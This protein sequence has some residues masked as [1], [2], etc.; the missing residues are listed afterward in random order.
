MCAA[1]QSH[2]RKALLPPKFKRGDLP[3]KAYLRILVPALQIRQWLMTHGLLTDAV[4]H[5]T[6]QTLPN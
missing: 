2:T 4:S 5:V 3:C 1:A 6:L